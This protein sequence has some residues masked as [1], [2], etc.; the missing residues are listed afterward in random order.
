MAKLYR[1]IE[2]VTFADGRR[3]LEMG[4]VDSLK[5]VTKKGIQVLMKKG[6]IAPVSSPPLKILPGWERKAEVLKEAKIEDV[7]DLLTADLPEVA[8]EL[9][10]SL[11]GL[12]EAADQARQWIEA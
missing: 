9:E 3:S 8:K 12:E 7:E 1:A 11:E 2:R 5:G 6:A 4:E 10:V